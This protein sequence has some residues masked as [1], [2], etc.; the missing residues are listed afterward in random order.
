MSKS[1]LHFNTHVYIHL[2]ESDSYILLLSKTYFLYNIEVEEN[3]INLWLV[4]CEFR[5]SYLLVT[6]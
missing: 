2:N 5:A 6:P 1:I 3:Q 4:F